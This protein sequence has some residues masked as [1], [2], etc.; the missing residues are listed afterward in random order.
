MLRPSLA[1]R[2]AVPVILSEARFLRAGSLPGSPASSCLSF[3]AE[4]AGFF[5]PLGSCQAVGPRSEESLFAS[6]AVCSGEFT[7]PSS[8][9]PAGLPRRG[10]TCRARLH[11]LPCSGG[12]FSP[13]SS[14]LRG[15]GT[16]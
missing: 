14:L 7:S 13:A 6:C 11:P 9:S 2:D 4:G 15:Q 16:G 3:R 1:Q 8:L 12:A 5:F 10:T